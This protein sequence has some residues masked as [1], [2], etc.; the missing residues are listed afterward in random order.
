MGLV[1][2]QVSVLAPIN[3]LFHQFMQVY[4]ENCCQLA[5]ALLFLAD[6]KENTL[7]K[8]FKAQNP[9]F[10]YNNLGIKCYYFCQKYK[11]YFE[12]IEAKIYKYMLFAATFF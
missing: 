10:C 5:L 4:I 7:K 1:I 6:F 2:Y 9:N 11:D 3:D 8:F 12:T